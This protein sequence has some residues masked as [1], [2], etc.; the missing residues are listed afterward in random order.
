MKDI[1]NGKYN[2]ILTSPEQC[3]SVDGHR[4]R[5]NMI[6]HDKPKFVRKIKHL[7]VDEA[8]LI[9]LWGSSLLGDIRETTPCAYALMA[10]SLSLMARPA[11]YGSEPLMGA[12]TRSREWLFEA[13]L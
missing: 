4:T 8:H 11:N 3:L 7:I 10:S 5:F 6:L 2:V 9:R 13:P 12:H 1:E